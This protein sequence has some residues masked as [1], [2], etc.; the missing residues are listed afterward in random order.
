MS[1]TS[2][3]STMNVSAVPSRAMETI[4]ISTNNIKARRPYELRAIGV[5]TQTGTA[6]EESGNSLY[7]HPK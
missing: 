5:W 1:A 2:D 3:L 4:V 7:L 6:L